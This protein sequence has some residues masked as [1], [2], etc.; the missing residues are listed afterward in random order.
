[1]QLEREIGKRLTARGWTLAVA[2]SCTGGGLGQRITSVAGSSAYFL[3]GVIAYANAAKVRFLGVSR[4]ALDEKGA[5]SSSV[6]CEM[7]AGARRRFGADVALSVTGVAGPGGGTARKP[8]GL[9]FVGLASATRSEAR[10]FRFTGGRG[11]VRRAAT[12]AALEWLKQQ[13]D[14]V[15]GGPQRGSATKE[16]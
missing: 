2:E 16:G 7:A 4:R 8:A 13:L 14:A 1:M 6:A 3:G 5:V 10:R 9:V 12:A 15:P 11:A